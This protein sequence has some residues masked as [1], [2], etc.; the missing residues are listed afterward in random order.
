MH[1][2][3]AALHEEVDRLNDLIAAL[4]RDIAAMRKRAR[5]A[6]ALAQARTILARPMPGAPPSVTRRAVPRSPWMTGIARLNDGTPVTRRAEPQPTW[7]TGSGV[8]DA[9]A[10]CAR[11]WLR[12]GVGEAAIRARLR[13]RL[14]LGIYDAATCVELEGRAA[15][16]TGAQ[17]QP[18][19]RMT[20]A[21]L[22]QA[23]P[24]ARFDLWAEVPAELSAG[25]RKVWCWY[26]EHCGPQPCLQPH[27]AKLA[28]ALC[29]A[30]AWLDAHP[31]TELRNMVKGNGFQWRMRALHTT[32]LRELCLTPRSAPNDGRRQ[33]RAP[34][35]AAAK[36]LARREAAKQA[37]DAALMPY[38]FQALMPSDER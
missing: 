13:D 29:E 16:R 32:L 38:D 3:D 11:I 28:I 20:R 2:Q 17:R 26:A 9:G 1:T 8:L 37:R 7:A 4:R 10:M 27:H 24:L 14:K 25:A 31:I 12:R 18:L 23:G 6:A 21:A 35:E 19:D 34:E 5:G 30:E 33:K 36:Q 15:V 22:D